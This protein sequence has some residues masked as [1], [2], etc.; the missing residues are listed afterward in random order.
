M[1][2]L[3]EVRNSVLDEL[4]RTGDMTAQAETAIMD[5][6]RYYE[7]FPFWFNEER[8]TSNT[9]DGQEYYALPQDFQDVYRVSVTVSSNKYLLIRRTAREMEALYISAANYR[10]YPQ[11]YSIERN[12]L[13][14]GPVPN[15]AYTLEMFY[16]KA[17]E[18]TT[19][20]SQTNIFLTNAEWLIRKRSAAELCL[21]ILQDAERAAHFKAMEQDELISLRSESARRT[22]RGHGYRRS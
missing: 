3:A 7:R 8:A 10:G 1:S 20:T 12:E 22:M 13:R 15:G 21:S 11:D 6:V 2:T 17:A 18:T 9:V 4:Y 16:R 19:A 14:L 5:A